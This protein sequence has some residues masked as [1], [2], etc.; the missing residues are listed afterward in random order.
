MKELYDGK[1]YFG[2][3]FEKL[4]MGNFILPSTE[5]IRRS[6]IH[7]K[8]MFNE[9]YKRA[10]DQD[11]HL[12]FS[13]NHAIAFLN[14]ST[15]DYRIH[16]ENKLSGK[17]NIPELIK[18]TID[19]RISVIHSNDNFLQNNKNL[20]K[21][22]LSKD[23]ARLSYY[24]LSVFNKKDAIAFAIESLKKKRFQFKAYYLLLLAM[25]P[26]KTLDILKNIKKYF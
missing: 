21:K 4:F 13:K 22:V 24:Y 20:V 10:E 23:Y 3:V 11:F 9:D 19:S 16:I 17:T 14:L 15:T 18:N 12:R 2:N 25:V 8:N 1:V 7:P 26:I 6:C 5:M